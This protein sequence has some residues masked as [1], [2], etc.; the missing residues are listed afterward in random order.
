MTIEEQGNLFTR[1]S[2]ATPR[3]HIHYGGSGLGLFISKKLAE[4]QAGAIGVFSEPD[5]GSTF[6]FF[7]ATRVAPPPTPMKGLECAEFPIPNR[8]DTFE[9][10]NIIE[11]QKPTSNCSVLIVEDNLVNVTNLTRER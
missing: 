6:A 10:G 9:G 1:F 3:T 8:Q 2:Q 4:L 5:V 7:M 11:V